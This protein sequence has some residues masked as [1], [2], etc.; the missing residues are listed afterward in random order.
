M[1]ETL[2]VYTLDRRPDLE[3]QLEVLNAAGWPEFMFQGGPLGWDL[4]FTTFASCQILLCDAHDRLLAFGHTIPF[5]WDGT[6]ADLPAT[7]REIIQRADEGRAVGVTPNTFSALAAV[8]DAREQGRGLSSRLIT[9]MRALAA[10]RRCTSLVAPVR[11]SWKSRYPLI[12]LATY[13]TW[14]RADGLPFD[15]WLR[16]HAR[17]GA[18]ML[19]VAPSTLRVTG[20]VADWEQWTSMEFPG[21]GLHIVPGALQPVLIDREADLGVYDDP[22]V[23]MHHRSSA[24]RTSWPLLSARFRRQAS[25]ELRFN[26]V[27]ISLTGDGITLSQEP[28]VV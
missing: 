13:A 14:R 8:V 17:L 2:T 27:S 20:S 26:Q 3:A 4:L 24:R 28:A 7:I 12:P 19:T 5:R 1:D 6:P 21:S 16:V 22:N 23:W 15:P 9:E 10:R 18:R 25:L 11:P